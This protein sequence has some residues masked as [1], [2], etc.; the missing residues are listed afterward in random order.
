MKPALKSKNR[1]HALINKN[2]VIK[3]WCDE[4]KDWNLTTARKLNDHVKDL[5]LTEKL[6]N[7]SLEGGKHKYIFKIR[8]RLKIKFSSK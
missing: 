8:N 4:C 6:F 1:T 7:K 3:I 5:K 2:F